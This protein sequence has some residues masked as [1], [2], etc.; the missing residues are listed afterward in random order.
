MALHDIINT[1]KEF[2][3]TNQTKDV[4]FRK[5][6]L[7]LLLE[8]IICHEDDILEALHDDLSKSKTEA[9]MT[10]IGIVKNEIKDALRH[11]AAWSRPQKVKGALLPVR[12]K[13]YIY[14]EPYGVVLILAP[15]NYPFN[16]TLMPLIGAIGA[17]NCAIVKCSDNSPHTARV[18]QTILEQCYPP[19]YI[20]CVNANL[21]HT[22]ILSETYDYIFFTGSPGVGKRIMKAAS[23]HL[24]P[25]T[26]ELG[27]KSPCFVDASANIDRAAKKIVWG[28]FM[29]AGQTCI[30]IDYIV[31]HESIKDALTNTMTQEI[32]KRYNHAEESDSY[33]SIV[34]TRHYK[35][36]IE[37]MN[38]ESVL[39]GG[40][41]NPA[42]RKIAPTLMPEADFDHE[43]MKDEIFGPLLPI[44]SYKNLDSVLDTIKRRPKP[45]SCYIFSKDKP[46]ISRIIQDLSYGG[47]CVNDTLLHIMNPHMPFGGVGYSGMGGYHGKFSFDTFSH[48][49]SVVM[50]TS[51]LDIPL[52]YAPFTDKTF[53]W[54][55]RFL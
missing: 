31:V 53:K 6:M 11:V 43:I 32:Q 50:N 44:I 41:V 1:Q 36:L 21:E 5:R 35:R 27:G 8:S 33:P 48:K 23:E 39:I 10:E 26:L 40:A 16:L 42:T 9:Y 12:S 49:K 15:W 18:I 22:L 55:K 2:F 28:K 52:R 25:I 19:E 38:T 34:N 7:K 3:H 13:N 51:F 29:N 20:Y 4:S 24:T 54:I 47:G 30:S 45:L 46:M 37:L 14:S 17:G